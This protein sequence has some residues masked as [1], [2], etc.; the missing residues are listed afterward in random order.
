MTNNK[1]AVHVATVTSTH[2]GKTYV[3]HLLRHTYREDGKVKQLTLGNLSDLPDD[4]ITVIKTRLAGA[5]LATTDDDFEIVR[6]LPHGHVVAALGMLRKIGLDRIVTSKPCRESQL[7]I[8]MI[9]LR[10]IAPSSKL[11]NLAGLQSETAEHSLANELQ[12]HDIQTPEIYAAMD[13]LFQR[14]TRIENKLAKKHLSDGT[15]VL[16][17]VS[18]SYY[19]GRQSELIK[20]GYNRDGKPGEPQIVPASFA[21]NHA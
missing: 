11:A 4:L 7:V 19:T 14:Q 10:I 8:A 17:D 1:R 21:V 20:M 13:W 2:K 6:S 5:P 9:V 16:Y 12:L 3:S 18:S 15:L